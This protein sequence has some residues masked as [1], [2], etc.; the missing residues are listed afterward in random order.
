MEIKS[1]RICINMKRALHLSKRIV[2]F[3][4][5][6]IAFLAVSGGTAFAATYSL[7][8]NSGYVKKGSDFAL[9]I[10]I[11][12]ENKEISLARAVITFDPTKIKLVEAERNNT[13]FATFPADDQSTDNT[14]GVVMITGFTQS[15]G[16][17]D[18][19]TTTGS[20]DVFARLKFKSLEEGT[21]EITWEFSGKDEDF[22]SVIMADGSPPQN[23]L[24]S[25]PKSAT[26]TIQGSSTPV[27]GAGIVSQKNLIVAGSAIIGAGLVFSGGSVL[28]SASKKVFTSNKRT[29]VEY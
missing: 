1:V 16:S 5:V 6:T 28:H 27:T 11:D 25:K 19:Y 14:N 9:D 7:T 21:A 2:A 22:K 18:L 20:A 24:T 12:S 23:V 29:L 8:P 15:G 26:Y 3:S 13:L 10:M 17:K 4:A